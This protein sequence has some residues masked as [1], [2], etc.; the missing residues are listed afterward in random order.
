MVLGLTIA[1]ITVAL[2]VSLAAWMLG[3]LNFGQAILAYVTLGWCVILGGALAK[4]LSFTIADRSRGHKYA[5]S[6]VVEVTVASRN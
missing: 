1:A 6:L 3:L 4:W 5:R 2:P